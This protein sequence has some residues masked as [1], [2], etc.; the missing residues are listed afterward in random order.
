MEPAP[1]SQSP[2]AGAEPSTV[3]DLAD[4]SP[5]GSEPEVHSGGEFVTGLRFKVGEVKD[6]FQSSDVF[7]FPANTQLNQLNIGIVGDLGT[8]KTQLIQA[9]IHQLRSNPAQNRGYAPRI[10]IF[11]Y[12]KDYSKPEFVKAT[13]ARVVQPFDIPLSL[14]D[15]R[16]SAVPER[17]WLDRSKFFG[18]VLDKIFSGIGPV[19]RQKIKEAVKAAYSLT[20]ESE[21]GFPT[22]DD[23]FGAYV[24]LVGD[25]VDS[26]YAIMSDL[27]DGG[28]F[29]SDPSKILPFSSFLDGV[30]V[31]DLG[32]VGQDDRTKNMLVAIFLNLFYE[33]MLVS[34]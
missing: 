21:L 12:K 34:R 33:H 15:T 26:P 22:L 30:V 5:A 23:V 19:Q 24:D 1:D 6:A 16:G 18:D 29:T 3:E 13:G 27:V 2:S 31:I 14:F 32:A 4:L 17:A 11:D 8:G 9:F 7:F 25:K 10:L 20:R 28:Y